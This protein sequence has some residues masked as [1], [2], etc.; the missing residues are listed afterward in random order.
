MK[1]I[2]KL[3]IE[4]IKLFLPKLDFGSVLVGTLVKLFFAASVSAVLI[5][6]GYYV[7]TKYQNYK[8]GEERTQKAEEAVRAIGAVNEGLIGDVKKTQES[9]TASVETVTNNAEVTAGIKDTTTKI[10]TDLDNTRKD[11]DA[12]KVIT[13]KKNKPTERKPNINDPPFVEPPPLTKTDANINAMWES[14]CS[15]GGSSQACEANS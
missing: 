6:G 12:G 15:L 13:P 8:N 3:F 4:I 2:Y 14:Y 11:I 7:K 10:L 9:G 5:G 1:I